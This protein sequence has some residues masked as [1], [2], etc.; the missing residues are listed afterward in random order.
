MIKKIIF[1][2]CLISIV[3]LVVFFTKR[4]V[5]NCSTIK[6]ASWG[7]ESEVSILKPLIA[8]FEK[9]HPD[10]KVEFMHIP[11]NYFQKIHLLF[12]SNTEPDVLFL[13]N[14][15]LPIYANAGRLEDLGKYC[16]KFECEK[17]YKNTLESMKYNN[18]LYAIPRD[19][20][21]LVV[22]YNKNLFDKY[23]IPYPNDD[24]DIEKFLE[25]S[26][27][28]TH[29][30]EVFGVSFEESPLYVFPYLNYFG[31]WTLDDTKNYFK[32]NVLDNTENKKG[33][34]FYSGLRKKYHVAPYKYESASATMAQMFLQQKIAMHISGRWLV[35]KYRADAKFDW[36]CVKFPTKSNGTV[37]MDTS[38][39]AI[40]K[41]SKNKDI[42]IEFVKFISNLESSKQFAKS[43]LIM[44]ARIDSANSEAFKDGK[45]PLNYN[46]FIESAKISRP[47][48]VTK[49]YNEILDSV[50]IKTE[51]M[52]N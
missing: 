27:K 21:N 11:Q 10:I 24:W 12:A 28:M 35:P 16:E 37:L 50:K 31:G 51:K 44:P 29:L 19:I 4:S 46:A 13:N 48:P 40:S 1:L 22:F 41:N 30:P 17:F 36:D 14:Q 33:L 23:K 6:F 34:E 3:G 5:V 42:A 20:S 32:E 25:I 38:G 7:S 39:W 52:F 2:F 45:K 9:L 15:Y 8:D 18:K 49:N 43:G 26:K 47:T